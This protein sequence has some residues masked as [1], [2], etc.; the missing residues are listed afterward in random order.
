MRSPQTMRMMQLMHRLIRG[1]SLD[2]WCNLRVAAKGVAEVV[3]LVGANGA[4]KTTSLLTIAGAL[5]K[6]DGT[7]HAAS[8]EVTRARPHEVA[9]TDLS[10]EQQMLARA[11][12]PSHPSRASPVAPGR[13]HSSSSVRT[14]RS[15]EADHTDPHR[16]ATKAQSRRF[17]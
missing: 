16:L 6:L 3:C 1:V 2:H 17:G 12:E 14:R 5:P 11:G 10:I 8:H 4:G 9:R 15:V 13:P 7:A